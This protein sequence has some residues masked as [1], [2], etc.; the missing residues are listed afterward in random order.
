[1]R[2]TTWAVILA[3]GEGSRL[4]SLTTD[5]DGSVVPKQY[6]SLRGGRSLLGDAVERARGAAG[7]RVATIVAAE[8]RRH[9]EREP[10]EPPARGHGFRIVQ[11]ANRGTA[12][13]ILLPLLAVAERDPDAVVLVL[14]SDHFVRREDVLAQALRGARRE[15]RADARAVILL[16]IAPEAAVTDYGWIVPGAGDG[17]ARPI[18]RFVEKPPLDTAAELLDAGGLWNSFLMAG[19]ARAFVDLFERRLPAHLHAFREC[20]AVPPGARPAAIERLYVDLPTADFSRDVL[21]GSEGCL[22]VLTVRPCGWTDLGTPA[23]VAAC[24]RG[25]ARQG[26]LRATT[27]APSTSGPLPER[28]LERKLET[29]VAR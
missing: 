10:L 20:F 13:G 18:E 27:P 6:W 3:A 11:P 17:N 19:T 12:P 14:P 28:V 2:D 15:A 9:W 21:Q 16:G 8:H 24:I 29:V 5:A 25:L 23:R 4:S 7:E 1:M 22:R 26:G